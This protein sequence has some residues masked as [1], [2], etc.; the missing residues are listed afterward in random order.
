[1]L[2][3]CGVACREGKALICKRPL[4]V[5][6]GGCWEFPSETLDEGDTLE[7]C[8]E[9]TFFERLSVKLDRACPMYT[10][11]SI[12]D[13][14]CRIFTFRAD[15]GDKTTDL[16]GYDGAKWVSFNK[17]A[18]FRLFPDS[19]TIVKGIEKFFKISV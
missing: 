9:R 7:D 5:P 13:K 14:G 3:V 8:L 6:Y 19:V 10:F 4:G 15:F 16:T 18:K 1:M 11:D 12:C 2:V 17:L